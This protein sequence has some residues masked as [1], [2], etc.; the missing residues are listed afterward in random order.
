LSPYGQ[1]TNFALLASSLHAISEAGAAADFAVVTGDLLA[2]D[3]QE[4]VAK[5]IG[6]AVTK[7]QIDDYAARTTGFV[8]DALGEALPGKSIILAL[9]NNDSDCGD[10][11]I[12]PGGPYLDATRDLVRRLAGGDLVAP[13]FDMTYDAGGY[14]AMRHPTIAGVQ[15][16]VLNDVLWSAEYQ[17][18]CGDGGKSAAQAML[19]WLEARLA[20]QQNAGRN[21]WL[22]HHIPIGIDAFAT[23]RSKEP[24][25]QDRAVSFL[26]A[27]FDVQYPKL[28]RDY[29]SI[30]QA[31]LTGHVHFDGYRLIFDA[32]EKAVGVEKIAPGI[33]PIFDQNP[34]F[35]R[36]DYDPQSGAPV[37]FSTIYLNNLMTAAN[38]AAGDWQVEYRFS[39][40]YGQKRYDASAVAAMWK[41]I[42]QPGPLR[43]IYQGYY[44]V[45][46]PKF[47]PTVPPPFYCAIGR[48]EQ[49]SFSSCACNDQGN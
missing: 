14:Y 45:G 9:G 21:V 11:R 1:D 42:S 49:S 39:E 20:E 29:A 41:S 37:D 4:K 5:K 17:D 15:I 19:A 40:A 47:N 8:A 23:M 46:S 22:V 6:A 30:I 2:H 43:D 16:I 35:H 27:P 33:S 44:D 25:C 38:P 3:F 26:A 13:D 10:Y 32:A 24:S 28:L 12:E 31:N 7:A 18:V 34:G 48:L 36:F